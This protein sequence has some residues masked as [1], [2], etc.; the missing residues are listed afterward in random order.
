MSS[1]IATDLRVNPFLHIDAATI[2]NPLTD[3][4]IVEG[5]GE[6]EALRRVI[7][8][9]EVDDR[10]E[11]DGWLVRGDVSRSYRLKIVSLETM[12]AC[13]QKCYFCPVSIAPRDDYDM[14]VE[15]F[16]RIVNQLTAHRDTLESVFLQSYNEPTLDRRFV[17]FCR[18]LFA[19]KLPVAVLSNGTGL[20]PAKVDALIESGPLRYICINLSTLDRERYTR[21]RGE[22]HLAAVLRNLDY[23]KTR[24]LA[25][26]MKIV[27]LGTGDNVHD[28]DFEAIRARFDGSRFIVEQHVVMDRAGWLD[29]GLKTGSSKKQLAGCDNVG[30]RPLQHLHITPRGACVL[31]CE[32]YDEKYVV[33]DLTQN[34]I[35]EVLEGPGLATMR[36]W[37]YG[38]EEAPDDFM[39]R[40]CVFAR[41]R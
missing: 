24:P 21:D 19:A 25:D 12:T 28:R 16:E 6:F 32:D 14:P 27:V 4:T 1:T 22:D 3:R 15:L 9:G 13:N 31:C 18:T 20:T 11:K 10:L 33:G 26:V 30:S 39:C 23:V 37:V 29:V 34:T 2:Y 40:D 38:I 36:R 41:T 5:D 17:D 7:D 8:G 35:E